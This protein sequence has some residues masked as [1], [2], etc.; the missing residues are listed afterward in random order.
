MGPKGAVRKC[1]ISLFA[2]EL[3]SIKETKINS[4]HPIVFASTILCRKAVV[5][6]AQ[7]IQKR[8]MQR[9]NKREA[10]HFKALIENT[11]HKALCNV[12]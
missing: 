11:F 9:L 7:V 4:K 3:H 5:M 12:G 6:G 8:I 1:F 10:I 2:S